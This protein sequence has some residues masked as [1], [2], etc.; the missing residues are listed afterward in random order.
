LNKV[1]NKLSNRLMQS[2]LKPTIEQLRSGD[3]DVAIKTLLDEGINPT[4][5]G[6]NKLKDRIWNINDEITNKIANSNATVNKQD[7]LN[8]LAG[9]N[10]KF[11][12]QV[13][14][15]KDIN[16][17]QGVADDFINH[18]LYAGA[19]IP[20]QDAQ[21]LKQGTYKVLKGKFNEVGS[22]ETE[23]QKALAKGLK[24][25][26]ANNVPD[27]GRLN[28]RE[29][30]LIKTLGVAERRALM[31]QN[32]NPMGLSLLANNP[33]TWAMFMA[34]RST[35]LKSLAARGVNNAS[36]FALS[37]KAQGLLEGISPRLFP[38]LGSQGLL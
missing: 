30:D 37:P 5:S 35:L 28:A 6:V 3:A 1:G 9:V 19:S 2:A 34:D 25:S 4:A 32:N 8:Q 20:V 17:I 13:N 21:K 7:V 38:V 14:P 26:I 23:A 10:S 29:S 11:M 12:S 27:V 22:A 33:Q 18:P 16:A 31:S 15:T 24:E 36:N